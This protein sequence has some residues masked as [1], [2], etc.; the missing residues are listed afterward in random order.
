MCWQPRDIGCS[1][2]LGRT[3]FKLSLHPR[4]SLSCPASPFCATFCSL[5]SRPADL[6]PQFAALRT[7]RLLFITR[8]NCTSNQWPNPCRSF[9]RPDNFAFVGQ[10]APIIT[11]PDPSPTPTP[12]SAHCLLRACESDSEELLDPPE[13]VTRRCCAKFALSVSLTTRQ[14]SL[15]SQSFKSIT[16]CPSQPRLHRDS[17]SPG[18]SN[19][20]ALLPLLIGSWFR[21]SAWP[22]YPYFDRLPLTS[23]SFL[24]FHHVPLRRRPA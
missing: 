2:R 17:P 9:L 18:C 8:S 14:A 1:R 7:F 15:Y 5:A 24:P 13:S 22:H 12:S 19:T 21:L 16:C 3:G 4:R 6:H 10:T 11:Y 23:S 20:V